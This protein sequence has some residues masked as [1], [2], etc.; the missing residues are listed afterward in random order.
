MLE[1]CSS[2]EVN[3]PTLRLY[4]LHSV[5]FQL[6]PADTLPEEGRERVLF[7][8]SYSPTRGSV[9]YVVVVSSS[10]DTLVI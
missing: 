1:L 10:A 9:L 2:V 6:F 8:L 5:P 7:V 3:D 4:D